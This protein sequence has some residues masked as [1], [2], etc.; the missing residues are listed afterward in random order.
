ME[1]REA[2]TGVG[3]AHLL[4]IGA[5]RAHWGRGARAGHT[6]GTRALLL[7][8]TRLRAGV[9]VSSTPDPRTAPPGRESRGGKLGHGS[10]TRSAAPRRLLPL[11]GAARCC[12]VGLRGAG[13]PGGGAATRPARCRPSMPSAASAAGSPGQ[14]GQSFLER[15]WGVGRRLL[16]VVGCIARAT[17]S[18]PGGLTPNSIPTTSSLVMPSLGM[19]WCLS[20]LKRAP[21]SVALANLVRFR[22]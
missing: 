20:E 14:P 18:H 22:A 7:P 2:A 11:P 3:G 5:P 9:G 21:G 4:K 12:A 19:D 16:V 13:Q 10:G 1:G 8:G 15:A 17:D 6:V